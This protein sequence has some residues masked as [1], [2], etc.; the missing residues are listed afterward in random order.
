MMG[1]KKRKNFPVCAFRLK[2]QFFLISFSNVF[3]ALWAHNIACLRGCKIIK[4]LW[5]SLVVRRSKENFYSEKKRFHFSSRCC[6]RLL[7]RKQVSYFLDSTHSH[8]SQEFTHQRKYYH[9]K[10]SFIS[11]HCEIIYTAKLLLLQ[12]AKR[13]KRSQLMIFKSPITW[14]SHEICLPSF[15][16]LLF[17]YF[18]FARSWE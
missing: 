10:L 4:L 13:R 18:S 2:N 17:S 15:L 6:I 11:H 7:P 9:I 5:L 8:L 3:I 16:L 12:C 1:M 14:F